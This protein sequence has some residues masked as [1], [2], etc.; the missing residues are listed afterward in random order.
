MCSNRISRIHIPCLLSIWTQLCEVS[1][2]E[3]IDWSGTRR[4]HNMRVRRYHQRTKYNRKS[5]MLSI[6][7]Q[8]MCTSWKHTYRY[9]RWKMKPTAS[10]QNSSKLLKLSIPISCCCSVLFIIGPVRHVL[11]HTRNKQKK[12]KQILP[13]NSGI[14]NP[15]VFQLFDGEI[16]VSFDFSSHVKTQPWHLNRERQSHRTSIPINGKAYL[17]WLSWHHRQANSKH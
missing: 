15:C 1:I 2:T 4:K 9:R 14:G 3:W 11:D 12:K 13:M 7:Q 17:R 5:L 6:H 16:A 8:T 10:H